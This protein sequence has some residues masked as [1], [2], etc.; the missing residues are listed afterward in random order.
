VT[1][2]PIRA[3][4][5]AAC[6]CMGGGWRMLFRNKKAGPIVVE[7]LL[8]TDVIRAVILVGSCDFNRCLLP[9]RLPTASWTVAGKPVLERLLTHLADQG[10][11]RVAVCSNCQMHSKLSHSSAS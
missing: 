5:S 9:S 11:K 3:V 8:G 1:R 10:I 6:V 2:E 4:A 7:K